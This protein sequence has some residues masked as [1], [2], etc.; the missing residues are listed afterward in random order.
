MA[1]LITP[2]E[3][4]TGALPDYDTYWCLV[5][6]EVSGDE[7]QDS[8]ITHCCDFLDVLASGESAADIANLVI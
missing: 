6:P 2:T 3:V 1:S 7:G 4:P 8:G 5:Y